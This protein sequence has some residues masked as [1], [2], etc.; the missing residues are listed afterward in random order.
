MVGPRVL[1]CADEAVDLL[2][3]LGGSHHVEFKSVEGGSLLYWEGCLYAVLDS[4][5]TITT[6]KLKEKNILF[7]FFKLVQAHIAAALASGDETGQGDASAR[8]PE[9]DLDLPF[10]EFLKKQGASSQD[11]SG[12]AW[13]WDGEEIKGGSHEVQ[14]S[15]KGSPFNT[16]A[17]LQESLPFRL[18]R[19]HGAPVVKAC[20]LS[21]EGAQIHSLLRGPVATAPP[22]SLP[23]RSSRESGQPT[24]SWHLT[25]AAHFRSICCQRRLGCPSPLLLSPCGRPM[26]NPRRATSRTRR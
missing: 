17:M 9:E 12:C 18:T 24:G 7:R 5:Q 8:I 15:Y 1:Y 10:V 3:R 25:V 19:R 26:V 14:S 11:E 16:M 22:H 23:W 4:R 2:L 20:G 21:M 13:E 6:L